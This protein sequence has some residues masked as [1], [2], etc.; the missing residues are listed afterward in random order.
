VLVV[1]QVA[2]VTAARYLLPC[3]VQPCRCEALITYSGTAQKGIGGE[4]GT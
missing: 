4:M 3:N 1:L 2:G